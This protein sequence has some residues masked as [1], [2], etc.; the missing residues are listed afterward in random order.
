MSE[1]LSGDT[2]EK[3]LSQDD[4]A[5]QENKAVEHRNNRYEENTRFEM[6]DDTEDFDYIK[7]LWMIKRQE[8]NQEVE[9]EAMG[10]FFSKVG[11]IE[12]RYIK[13]ADFDWRRYWLQIEVELLQ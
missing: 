11:L 8:G 5:F 7:C 10:T 3:N 13:N 2:K 6:L 4:A 12:E 9:A 1:V